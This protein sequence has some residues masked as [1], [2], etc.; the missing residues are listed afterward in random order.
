MKWRIEPVFEQKKQISGMW[1]EFV[2]YYIR[3]GQGKFWAAEKQ[4]GCCV[5]L[6]M[7]KGN[8]NYIE[9]KMKNNIRHAI[10]YFIFWYSC[11]VLCFF[12]K[13]STLQNFLYGV[14]LIKRTTSEAQDLKLS[15]HADTSKG[16]GI[17]SS[18]WYPKLK[19]K[20]R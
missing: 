19:M 11:N 1:G 14:R 2:F 16:G 6:K 17:K 12:M 15:S 10:L 9:M 4:V 8:T 5:L 20:V 13:R 18:R 3:N 7:S